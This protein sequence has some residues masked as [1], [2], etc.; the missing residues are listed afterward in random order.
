MSE[1]QGKPNPSKKPGP[2]KPQEN[3]AH[4]GAAHAA[5][6][7][8]LS[9]G[10]K[11]G[12]QKFGFCDQHYDHFKFG[13]IKKTGEPVSDYEKKLEHYKAYVARSVQKVA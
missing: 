4:G 5:P 1:A 11:A 12:I 13:L 3:Q 6:V 2:A 8:C 10:C 7:H 9:S